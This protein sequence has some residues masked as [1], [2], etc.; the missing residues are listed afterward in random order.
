ML[1]QAWDVDGKSLGRAEVLLR[2]AEVENKRRC[3]GGG[4]GEGG[5]AV[6]GL[7]AWKGGF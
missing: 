7:Q 3:W 5:P 4:A 6:T 2:G 1:P